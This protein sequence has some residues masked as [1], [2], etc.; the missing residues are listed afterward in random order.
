MQ[1][2]VDTYHDEW[3]EV[4]KDPQRR[5][6]FKQFVN[7][8]EIQTREQMIE[9]INQRG[10][11]R[12][13]NWREDGEFQTN[14]RNEYTDVFARSEKA[15]VKVG[16]VSDFAPNVGSTI[17]YGESQL[18]VFNNLKLG[19]WYCT[20]NICPHKQA[21]VLSQGIMGDVDGISKVRFCMAVRLI[22]KAHFQI[23][24]DNFTTLSI[25]SKDCMSSTQEAVWIGE[26]TAA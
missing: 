14:W 15:W 3:A 19:E 24:T 22:S 8:D 6:K 25:P 11:V 21:F 18:A 26:W 10:Q 12:P 1:Y 17:L 16:L 13:T 7:T 2:L 4:V 9:F 23:T 20:Q 5:A